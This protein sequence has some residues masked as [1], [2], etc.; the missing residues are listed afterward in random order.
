MKNLE[1]DALFGEGRGLNVLNT[2]VFISSPA[3]KPS[4]SVNTMKRPFED[5]N[6]LWGRVES[7]MDWDMRSPEHVELDEL[8]GMFDDL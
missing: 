7:T 3:M 2:A 8:D 4:L 5:S 6:D 1:T